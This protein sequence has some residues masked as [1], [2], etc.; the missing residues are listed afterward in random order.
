[1]KFKQSPAHIYAK[2][3]YWKVI[4]WKVRYE[5]ACMTLRSEHLVAY[6]IKIHSTLTE[7]C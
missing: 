2:L 3:T 5:S 4:L 1:M 6:V 7:N